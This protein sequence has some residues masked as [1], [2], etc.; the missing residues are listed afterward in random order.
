MLQIATANPCGDPSEPLPNKGEFNLAKNGNFNAQ[1]DYWNPFGS[2]YNLVHTLSRSGS[3][4]QPCA[5]VENDNDDASSGFTQL[6]EINQIKPEPILVKM[7]SK[8]KDVSGTSKDAGYSLYVDI[9]YSDGSNDWGFNVPFNP[10]THGWERAAAFITKDNPS[11]LSKY[12]ACCVVKK[13]K[14]GL[15]ILPSR[16]GNTPRALAANAKCLNPLRMGIANSAW[17]VC[18]VSWETCSIRPCSRSFY[19]KVLSHSL[20][21]LRYH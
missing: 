3:G 12:T 17:L 1:K 14:H 7:W 18:D 13:A 19:N 10:G 15:T 9:W 11:N 6:I 2:G 4:P 20:S 16:E 5:H 21:S 8:S